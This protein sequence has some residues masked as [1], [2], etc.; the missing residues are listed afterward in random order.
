MRTGRASL[1]AAA[2]L[3]GRQ[4]PRAAWRRRGHPARPGPAGRLPPRPASRPAHARLWRQDPS[5]ARPLLQPAGS[6]HPRAPSVARGG[7][8]GRGPLGRTFHEE[9]GNPP[10]VRRG[11]A[12]WAE[13]AGP[14]RD[15]T[16]PG[17]AA[18]C[19]LFPARAGLSRRRRDRRHR[20]GAAAAPGRR[21]DRANRGAGAL[22]RRR[23]AREGQS[24]RPGVAG[25][26]TGARHRPQ[27]AR[28]SA[29]AGRR[30]GIRHERPAP[31]WDRRWRVR[32][33]LCRLESRAERRTAAATWS[34][35]PRSADMLA[36]G[37]SRRDGG[38]AGPGRRRAWPARRRRRFVA[39]RRRARRSALRLRPSRAA[40]A[41]CDT[42]RAGP[43]LSGAWPGPEPFPLR[44]G[45]A[46]R[47]GLRIPPPR[48][49]PPAGRASARSGAAGG[50]RRPTIRL[51]RPGSRAQAPLASPAGE[52]GPASGAE[53]RPAA[54]RDV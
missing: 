16:H 47:T 20:P 13:N 6:P 40:A 22:D 24:A 1:I 15:G 3:R 10:S 53:A 46:S 54:A 23:P 51:L 50:R 17:R 14:V 52:R 11:S 19:G 12:A 25:P 34:A 2:S 8:A 7:G 31:R 45:A 41:L 42:R 33:G 29:A 49:R 39:R 18:A 28:A 36:D 30:A 27:A 32:R 37:A 26:P 38:P 44:P 5:G 4:A 9:A 35:A 43:P 48:G 21:A